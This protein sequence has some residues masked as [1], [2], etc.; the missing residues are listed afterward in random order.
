MIQNT[1]FKET[2]ELETKCTSCLGTGTYWQDS[3]PDQLVCELCDGAGL[4]PTEQGEKI[5]ELLRHN[6]R[7]LII[8]LRDN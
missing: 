6:I 1:L 7:P 2:F 5:L 4:V 3:S 8:R